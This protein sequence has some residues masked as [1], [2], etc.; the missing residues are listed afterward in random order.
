MGCPTTRQ[1]GRRRASFFD[2]DGLRANWTEPEGSQ[3]SKSRTVEYHGVG[4]SKKPIE[5]GIHVAS[6]SYGNSFWNVRPSWHDRLCKC[7]R[8]LCPLHRR[9]GAGKSR[10]TPEPMRVRHAERVSCK[11]KRKRWWN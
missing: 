7:R 5:V 4:G 6:A 10:L 9:P 2:A 3:K 11:R 1:L 8:L